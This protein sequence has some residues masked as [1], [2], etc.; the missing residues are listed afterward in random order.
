MTVLA[1][2]LVVWLVTKIVTESVLFEPVR[3]WVAGDHWV[4]HPA[5]IDGFIEARWESRR[6]KLAYLAHCNLCAGTWIGLATA[7]VI[8]GPFGL[9]L[10][11][12]LLFKAVAHLVL[13]VEHLLERV[14]R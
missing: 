11:N 1:A 13:S 3:E 8:P 5:H 4:H 12:G 14:A 10:L 2:G 6:P 9:F 7:L